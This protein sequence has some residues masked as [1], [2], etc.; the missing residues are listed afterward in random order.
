[1]ILK[2]ILS[3]LDSK[4]KKNLESLLFLLKPRDH[5][6]TVEEAAVGDVYSFMDK[7]A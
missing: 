3:S 2:H 7:L 4:I 5:N 6:K 1:M